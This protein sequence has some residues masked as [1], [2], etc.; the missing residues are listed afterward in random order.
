LHIGFLFRLRKSLHVRLFI[1]HSGGGF[2]SKI[3][4]TLRASVAGFGAVGPCGP[5]PGN[6]SGTLPGN[7]SGVGDSPGSRIGGE[8]SGCGL[9]GGDS[10][11]GSVG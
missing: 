1:A 3:G 11:G 7:S 5:R 6:S 4:Q 9:P 10:I 8:I 2:K